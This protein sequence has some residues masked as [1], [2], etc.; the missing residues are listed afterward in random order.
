MSPEP[1]VSKG[2]KMSAPHKSEC[3]LAGGH[4]AK[5][6]TVTG[7]PFTSTALEAEPLPLTLK[8]QPSTATALCRW[9]SD[10]AFWCVVGGI[11]TH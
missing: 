2:R 3:P 1:L 8:G 6:I 4:V 9:L 11:T 7:Q 10:P 5:E